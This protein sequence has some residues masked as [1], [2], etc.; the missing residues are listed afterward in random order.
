[1]LFR[2]VGHVRATDGDRQVKG[3]RAI[4]RVPTG[5][6]VVTGNPEARDATT[7]LKGSEVRMTVGDAN[8]EVRDAVVTVESAK[9]PSTAP[10]PP[11][12]GGS[13]KP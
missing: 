4:F 2:S 11:P 6:L 5:L 7:H 10:T 13:R 12:A 3:E 8:F 9:P 1:M